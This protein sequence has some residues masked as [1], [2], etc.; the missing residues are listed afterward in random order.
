MK[1]FV[2][3]LILLSVL[4]RPAWAWPTF[5]VDSFL[6]LRDTPTS[7]GGESGNCVAANATETALE[8]VACGGGGSSKWTDAGALTHLTSTTDDVG[9]GG[10]TEAGVDHFW[11]S[12]GAAVLNEQGAAV[13]IRAEGGTDIN[14]LFLDGSA[15]FIG[16]G[17]ATPA[18]KLHITGNTRTSGE[19]IEDTGSSGTGNTVVNNSLIFV[20]SADTSITAG[21]GI[22]VTNALMRVQGS[23]GAVDITV[24]PQIAA[25]TDGEIVIIQGVNDTNTVTLDDGTGLALCGGVSMTLGINDNISLMYDSGETE[26]LEWGGRCDLN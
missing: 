13:D 9:I 11:G 20:P 18:E 24:D 2:F 25:G 10:T 8:F 23:G 22:T 3:T 14:L 12:D 16:V 15:D 26:W 21:G 5:S 1:K 6:G 4:M 7:Y 19:F 17:N